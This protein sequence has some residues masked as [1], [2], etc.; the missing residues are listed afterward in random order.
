[1]AGI[2]KAP[3]NSSYGLRPYCSKQCADEQE[4]GPFPKKFKCKYKTRQQIATKDKHDAVQGSH[5]S[6][7]WT[8]QERL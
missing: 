7:Q 5:K 4:N 2:T 1:M 6:R 8:S 3:G